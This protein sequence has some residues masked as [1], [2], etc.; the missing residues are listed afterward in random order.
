VRA[1]AVSLSSL[2]ADNAVVRDDESVA[3][4]DRADFVT[5]G[6]LPG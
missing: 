6:R 1:R 4:K 2:R 3:A 5:R